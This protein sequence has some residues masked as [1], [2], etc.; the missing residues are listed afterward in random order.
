[1]FKAS[2]RLCIQIYREEQHKQRCVASGILFQ[3]CLNVIKH[4]LCVN[5]SV[6][7]TNGTLYIDVYLAVANPGLI[8]VK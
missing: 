1:M 4:L 5:S 8:S 6:T 7:I 2:V 3:L